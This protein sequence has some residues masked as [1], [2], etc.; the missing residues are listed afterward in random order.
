MAAAATSSPSSSSSSKSPS[1]HLS[2]KPI[3]LV[4]IF[5]LV[6][7]S[8]TATRPG[9]MMMAEQEESN[10]RAHMNPQEHKFKTSFQQGGQMFNFFPKGV[11]IPPSGPSKRH[12][13]FVDSTPN[14]WSVEALSRVSFL[15][16]W[17]LSFSFCFLGILLGGSIA[18]EWLLFF[19]FFFPGF[20]ILDYTV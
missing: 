7:G 15:Y 4:F 13:S 19:P 20:V 18:L 10:E 5:F 6:V 1:M 16:I 12:N 2:C 3:C 17:L 14:N 8:C 11:P 9:R